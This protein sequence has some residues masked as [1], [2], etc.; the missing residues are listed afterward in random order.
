MQANTE[1]VNIH[2][3]RIYPIYRVFIPELLTSADEP[4]AVLPRPWWHVTLRCKVQLWELSLGLKLKPWFEMIVAWQ[5]LALRLFW[6]PSRLDRFQFG[7]TGIFTFP[8]LVCFMFNADS[9]DCN[10]MERPLFKKAWVNI[11][12]RV[13]CTSWSRYTL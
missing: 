10:I 3:L 4:V 7:F 9:S 5:G 8:K 1:R 2:N 11:I 13:T 6:V 12:K